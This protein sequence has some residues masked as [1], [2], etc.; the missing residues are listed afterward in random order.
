MTNDQAI[1]T[2]FAGTNGAGKSTISFQMKDYVGVIIDP[3][4]IARTINPDNPRNA[5]LSA[6]MSLRAK[7]CIP[8]KGH[9]LFMLILLD[10]ILSLM[11]MEEQHDGY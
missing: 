9:R 7:G 10:S 4:Q 3:D 2:V 6:G 1:L 5:D 8:L 11:G